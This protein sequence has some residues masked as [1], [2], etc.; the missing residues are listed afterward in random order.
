MDI[1]EDDDFYAPEESAPDV[2][3]PP[4][5]VEEAPAI[6][7]Q[8]DEDEDLEEGE[9]EDEADDGSDSVWQIIGWNWICAHV[10]KGH[11]YHYRTKRW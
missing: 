2:S 10:Y 7:A 5:K 8:T 6:S 4:E 9:E 1:D 3:E 11:R